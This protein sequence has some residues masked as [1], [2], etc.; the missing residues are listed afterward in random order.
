MLDDIILER[1]ISD[2]IFLVAPRKAPNW[3][4]EELTFLRKNHSKMTDWQ[5]GDLL[6]RTENGIKIKR[7][8]MGLSSAARTATEL[9]PVRKSADLLGIDMHKLSG[10]CDA[11]MIKFTTTGPLRQVRLIRYIDLQLFAINPANWM[12]FNWRNIEDLHL[13]R[14]CELRAERWGDEWWTT[15]QVAQHHGVVVGI[16]SKHIRLGWLD[17]YVPPKSIGGRAGQRAWKLGFVRKS[18]A[19]KY[20]FRKMA[21]SQSLSTITPRADAW[22]IRAVDE[23]HMSFSAIARTM[24]YRSGTT[25]VNRYNYLKR[26]QH[27]RIMDEER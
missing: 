8:R 7:V 3:T 24:S 11:G 22:I 13:R 14:L 18:V 4:D 1:M 27:E 2:S 9:I 25:I 19:L 17:G 26:R 10:W 15:V 23:L 16:V 5:L 12:L 20:T 21:G 6:G